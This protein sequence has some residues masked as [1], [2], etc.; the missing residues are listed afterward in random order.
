MNNGWHLPAKLYVSVAANTHGEYWQAERYV[1]H[2]ICSEV[3]IESKLPWYMS[4]RLDGRL[5]PS[6][7]VREGEQG[8][9]LLT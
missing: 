3:I 7:G 1:D 4:I 8:K 9:M 5:S 6:F 2:T